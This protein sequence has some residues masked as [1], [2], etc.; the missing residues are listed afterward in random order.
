MVGPASPVNFEEDAQTV[1]DQ[2][3]WF[4]GKINGTSGAQYT[5]SFKYPNIELKR[6]FEAKKFKE[7]NKMITRLATVRQ[8]TLRTGHMPP[9]SRSLG[10]GTPQLMRGR[11]SGRA[12]EVAPDLY[13]P[14]DVSVSDSRQDERHDTPCEQ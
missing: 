5:P 12:T 6:C 13:T 11:Q 14:M 10:T 2:L 9:N 4:E 1:T 8:G 3:T 7:S